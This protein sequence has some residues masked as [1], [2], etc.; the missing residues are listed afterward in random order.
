M[1][2]SSRTFPGQWWAR[3]MSIASRLNPLTLLPVL[4]QNSLR[5]TWDRPTMSSFRSRSGGN[6]MVKTL[7]R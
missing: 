1:F 7:R 4:W 2:S 3:S 6:V 5:K